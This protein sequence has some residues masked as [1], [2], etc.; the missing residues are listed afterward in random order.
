[1]RLRS[2][3]PPIAA[4]RSRITRLHG[5]VRSDP[6]AWLQGLDDPETAA[7]LAAENAY[8][9][10]ATAYTRALRRRLYQEMLS[11]LPA[12]DGSL[13]APRG[14]YLYYRRLEKER[15]YPVHCRRR[16]PDGREEVL[17]DENELAAG[18]P[19]FHL[20]LFAV[21]PDQRLLL[22]GCDTR[23]DE[24]FELRI[25]DLESGRLLPERLR[26]NG[27]TATWA[28][29]SWTLF[30][31]RLDGH[32]RR[33]RLLRHVVGQDPAR[34]AVAYEE[35]DPAVHLS[36]GRSESGEYL[37]LA[38]ASR[39]TSEVRAL[40]AVRPGGEW[41][42]LAPRR[43]GV[44][45]SVSHQG[46]LFYVLT[47][48]GAPNFKVMA[49]AAAAGGRGPWSTVVP[50]R[51]RVLIEDVRA[52]AGH[53]VLHERE[54]G[55]PRLRVLD[56]GSGASHR[57][58]LPGEVFALHPE[59]NRD[60]QA[61]VF[62]FGY[63]S[64]TEPYAVYEHDMAKRCLTLRKRTLVG[65]GFDPRRYTARRLRARGADGTLI[66]I[67][68]VSR[69]SGPASTEHGAPS[70]P[71]PL[72]LCGY[73]AY[74]ISLDL[75]F[76]PWWPCLLD[77]GFILAFAH[78]RG[79]GELGPA[80]HEQGR[81]LAKPNSF[82]DF[83]A[84]AEHLIASGYTR[85]DRLAAMGESAGG[86]LIGAVANHRPD[87]F[88]ALV[89]RVPF[90]DP[91]SSLLDSGLP[92]TAADWEEFGDPRDRPFHDCIKSYSPYENVTSQAYP[93]MLVMAALNDPR[94]P[95]WEAAK[96]VARLRACNTGGAPLLLMTDREAGHLGSGDRFE[97]LA[98][99]SWVL[100]FV[101]DR[102]GR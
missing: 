1:M 5:E 78:V 93:A 24:S 79:G 86:L 38:L 48:D 98:E 82:E 12:A 4:P 102:T 31:D 76:S 44:E 30:Y 91:L 8:A 47:N 45:Y 68:L 51:E 22:Y 19:F 88:S 3:T 11:R 10:A 36:V 75:S 43:E 9:E 50:H 34:D 67:S 17:L 92:L 99:M 29:D 85:P 81:L 33:A 90:V 14:G 84:C 40:P 35:R 56:T 27:G 69:R 80:W 49:T 65:G 87:L 15:A 70:R 13:P 16:I 23:G 28:A 64:P 2:T 39:R 54:A 59:E 101:I 20:G 41:R 55:V 71:A 66:P 46:D 72:L 52:F 7:Y 77:R 89:A 95:C 94:V 74:G 60:F 57:V 42:P 6:Y 96:W 100:A 37:L 18:H 73:G 63:S 53:L 25:K 26:G 32:G 21:S 97:Q 83:I 61:S 62:R 58:P